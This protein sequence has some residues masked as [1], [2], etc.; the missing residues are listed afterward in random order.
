MDGKLNP[1]NHCVLMIHGEAEYQE[2]SHR[3]RQGREFAAQQRAALEN[4]GFTLE[5]VERGMEPLLSFHA[6]LAEDIKRYE[7][8]RR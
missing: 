2:S 7:Q 3:L 5:E 8:Q 6:Q 4:A 1:H